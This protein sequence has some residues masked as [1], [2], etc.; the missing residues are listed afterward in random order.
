MNRPAPIDLNL[1]EHNQWL[2]YYPFMM[3][4]DKFDG[5]FNIFGDSL[6]RLCARNKTEDVSLNVFN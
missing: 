6:S 5:G 1:D 4:L 3:S 2:Y